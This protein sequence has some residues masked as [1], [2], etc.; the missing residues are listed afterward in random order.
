MAF[1]QATD[2]ELHLRNV[3][4]EEYRVLHPGND[5]YQHEAGGQDEVLSN[6]GDNVN[7]TSNLEVPIIEDVSVFSGGGREGSGVH[8]QEGLRVGD[9]AVPQDDQV[10]A[11]PGERREV[12]ENP[13]TINERVVFNPGSRPHSSRAGSVAEASILSIAGKRFQ[14]LKSKL[15]NK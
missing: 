7:R 4:D 15:L 14:R 11:V 3:I 1:L 2:E 10:H 12:T 13:P 6:N 5:T 9:A 8:F